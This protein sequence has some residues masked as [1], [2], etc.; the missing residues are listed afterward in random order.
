MIAK[1][2]LCYLYRTAAALAFGLNKKGLEQSVLAF[3]IGGSSVDVSLLT[4][5]QGVFEVVATSGDT[6]LGGEDFDER[7]MNFLIEKYQMTTGL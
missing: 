5:D 3:S 6:N 7:V 1:T 4:I 2:K